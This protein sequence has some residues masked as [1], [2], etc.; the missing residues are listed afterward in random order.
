MQRVTSLY[1][2][3]DRHNIPLAE[4]GRR[5][6]AKRQDQFVSSLDVRNPKAVGQLID[7]WSL[8]VH[9]SAEGCLAL[10]RQYNQLGASMVPSTCQR[11]VVRPRPETSRSPAV[12]MRLLSRKSSRTTS[13]SAR[14]SWGSEREQLDVKFYIP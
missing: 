6:M 9:R 4:D 7:P 3:L 12:T 1:R 13:V 11:A 8:H 5:W 2:Q 10:V 14:P